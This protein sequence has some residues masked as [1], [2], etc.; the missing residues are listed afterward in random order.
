[1]TIPKLVLEGDSLDD[2]TRLSYETIREASGGTITDF[3]EGSPVAALVEGQVFALSELLYYVNL[4]PEAIA[5]EVFRLY[6]VQRNLGTSASGE[7]TFLLQ[8]SS[9][10]AFSLPIGYSL[11]YQ[12]TTLVLTSVLFIPPGATSGKASVKSLGAGLKYNAAPYGALVT[13][14]GIAG[15]QSVYN[16]LALTGGS[17]LEDISDTISRGQAEISSRQALI[18]S[19]DYELAAVA[20]LGSG[21]R[22]I[23]VPNLAS[24]KAT[25]AFGN[26][27][28]FL[29]DASG[30]PASATTIADIKLRL[31]ERTIIGTLLWLFPMELAPISVDIY[32][33]VEQLDE[34]INRDI[35][36]TIADYLKPE[37][38]NGGYKVRYNEL[39][40]LARQIDGCTSVESVLI[41]NNA[42]DYLLPN[43]Y[44]L[45]SLT[46]INIS[47][48]DKQGRVL[49]TLV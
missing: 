3:R 18:S 38:Y 5:L 24:D 35:I 9:S 13:T 10:I 31:A 46:G 7:L 33:Q 2:L 25:L 41:N 39:A 26:V 32:V 14:P 36:E 49:E 42:I 1:M 11:P 48:V 21:S 27:G 45:P 47:Q 22:A 40:Y 29:L 6:G 23:C 4:L 44:T 34:S 17:D 19:D 43:Q 37:L 30:Q 12:D 16:E 20:A 8:F 15:V 28:L